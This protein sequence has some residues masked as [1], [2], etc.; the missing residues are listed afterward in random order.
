LVVVIDS[1]DP[2]FFPD[3]VLGS[4]LLF[5]NTSQVLPYIQTDPSAKFSSNGIANGDINGVSSVG[6]TNGIS[7]PNTMFQADAN[8]GITAVPEPMS[9]VLLG[10][11]LMG[12]A[13]FSRLRGIKR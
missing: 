7:G 11:G 10:V 8:I 1:F 6:A 3:L 5:A 13:G 9:L 2:T 4:T 12:V